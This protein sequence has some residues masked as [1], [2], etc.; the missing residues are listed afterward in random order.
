ML[1]PKIARLVGLIED[2]PPGVAPDMGNLMIL[3]RQFGAAASDMDKSTSRPGSIGVDLIDDFVES[4]SAS[5]SGMMKDANRLWSRMRKA[6]TIERAIAKAETAQ[7]GMEAGLRAEFKSIY[8]GIVDGNKKCRGFTADETKAIKAVAQGN[9]TANVLRRIASLGG[10]SGPQRAMQNL[11]QG[12]GLGFALGAGRRG[13][14]R[15]G[16]PGGRTGCRAH[17]DPGNAA[18]GEPRASDRSARRDSETG[19]EGAAGYDAARADGRLHGVARMTDLALVIFRAAILAATTAPRPG[20]AP[21]RISI[22]SQSGFC[23]AGG[24][25]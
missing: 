21:R 20:R 10:G 24:S 13:D 19:A 25:C 22:S 6:E 3:R 4:G 1:H 11:I 17:G 7:Q 16:R 23:A 14:W 8:R 2:T 12:G 9:L 15:G 18:A 5:A